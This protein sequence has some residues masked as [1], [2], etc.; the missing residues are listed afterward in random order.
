MSAIQNV[1]RLMLRDQVAPEL[2]GLGLKGSGGL[3]RLDTDDCWARLGFQSSRYNTG[4][5]MRF[6]VNLCVVSRLVWESARRE[7]PHLPPQPSPTFAYVGGRR[8]TWHCRI[9]AC[10][11][12][13]QDLWWS[14]TS[15]KQVVELS[16]E[17]VAAVRDFGLPE[18]RKRL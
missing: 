16:G 3:Y 8:A 4:E 14:L 2:R 15:E 1:Y 13:G 7:L 11:P 6:T 10:M 17:V 9:G 12:G 5:T 18:L